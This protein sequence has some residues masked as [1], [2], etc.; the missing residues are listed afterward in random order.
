MNSGP[1]SSNIATFDNTAITYTFYV[2]DNQ[3]GNQDYVMTTTATNGQGIAAS[4]SFTITILKDCSRATITLP[5]S[6]FD[7]SATYATHVHNLALLSIPHSLP[8]I[9]DNYCYIDNLLQYKQKG[10]SDSSY[11]DYKISSKK[12]NLFDAN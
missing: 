1:I 6:T 3:Y 8:T 4:V 9:D 10:A 11:L 2:T 5:I 7:V 12:A